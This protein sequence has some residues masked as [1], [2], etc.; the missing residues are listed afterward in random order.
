MFMK[1][2]TPAPVTE[3]H[4]REVKTGVLLLPDERVVEIS[5]G[6]DH[7]CGVSGELSGRCRCKF[8]RLY[9]QLREMGW[10]GT[11][12]TALIVGD[13]AEWIWNRATWFVRRRELLDF[14]HA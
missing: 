7:W 1:A 5:P 2:K 4:F 8:Q 11:N 13:G 9:A 6:D 14:W 3:G 10:A 12:T